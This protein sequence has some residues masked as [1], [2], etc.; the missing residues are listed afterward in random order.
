VLQDAQAAAVIGRGLKVSGL[1]HG[2]DLGR[3]AAAIQYSTAPAAPEIKRETLAYIIYTSGSTGKPKGV[4]VTHGNLLN[5]VFWHRRAFAVTAADRASH[6]AG[7]A[8]DAAMWELWPYLSAGASVVL[9][10]DTTRTSPDLL[11]EWLGNE[12][13]TISFVPTALAEPMLKSSWKTTTLRYLLT[14]ADTLHKFPAAGLP[15]EL[16]NNYG[17]TECTVVA[18]SG[19]VKAGGELQ[20]PAIGAAIANTQIYLLD[21]RLEPVKPGSTGEIYIGGTSVARGYRSQPALTAERFLPNPFSAS[22]DARM[23]R[24]GDMGAM[25]PDGQIAFHGRAD[26]QEKIRGHRIEPGEIVNVLGRHPKVASSAVAGFGSGSVRQLAAYVVPV[27]GQR[28]KSSELREFLAKELPE[29]MIPASFVRMA[30]LPLTTNGKLDRAALPE[31]SAANALDKTMF[32]APESPIEIQIAAILGDLLHV[33]NVGLDDNFF[34]LGGHS[35]LGT[36]LVLKAKERFGVALTLRDL[37]VAQTV[38]KLSDEIERQ[39]M[40]N[41]EAMSEEE[42]AAM[43]AR[44]DAN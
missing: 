30:S 2:V 31:P 15:F 27:A 22:M 21:E 41:L 35:L 18:T 20:K 38:G 13:V 3:D 23:Y 34:L 29:Y 9:A 14:G 43:L 24:T 1:R 8:F 25:L 5:L 32:R 42:A 11:R 16:V 26:H 19:I 6:V 36:Q 37:F 33:T 40:A 28:P 7:L 4:E 39:L 17:P 44:L 12:G 10:D